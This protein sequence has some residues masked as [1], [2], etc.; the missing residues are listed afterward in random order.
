MPPSQD[1]QPQEPPPP[2]RDAPSA[3]TP[4]D[5]GAD[6][7]IEVSD[8]G[9]GA[10]PS[11]TVDDQ[12]GA[13]AADARLPVLPA[14]D[15]PLRGRSPF[16]ARPNTRRRRALAGASVALAVVLTLA[17]LIVI[18]VPHPGAAL[19]TLLRL[20]TPTATPLLQFGDDQVVV[21]RGVYWGQLTVDGRAVATSA[22]ASQPLQLARGAHRIL[23]RAQFFPT[24]HCRLSVP[25]AG[26][27]TCP[28]LAQSAIDT[29]SGTF[30]RTR[31]LDLQATVNRL[32]AA[33]SQR[34]LTAFMSA[35]AGLTRTGVIAP[36]EQY[37]S[38]HGQVTTATAPLSAT[39][40]P[41]VAASRHLYHA[42][43][44]NSAQ[45]EDACDPLCDFQGSFGVDLQSWPLATYL[46]TAW[47]YGLPT[48]QTITAPR[49]TLPLGQR[50]LP[51]FAWWDAAGWHVSLSPL[52]VGDVEC[53]LGQQQLAQMAVQTSVSGFALEPVPSADV[54]QGCLLL[55]QPPSATQ[56]LSAAAQLLY[57]YG[58]LLAANAMA[59]QLFPSVPP[60][61]A[62]EMVVAQ[63]LAA[64]VQPSPSG[65]T[66]T[67][68]ANA[69]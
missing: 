64:E 19:G 49:P 32:P 33:Q 41:S 6:F 18:S 1:A 38:A 9:A 12:R 56:P 10:T 3:A 31:I 34:L 44:P 37:V 57:R 45:E 52:I 55:Y 65:I 22:L 40:I 21:A 42:G 28:L 5:D 48:G 46:Y 4:P 63:R 53:A 20:P 11:A 17:I 2:L 54:T 8:L 50:I 47:R 62:A 68:V 25:A 16:A 39:L 23:Y 27:D 24:L 30:G 7:E 60:A 67:P 59:R 69:S 66:F 35:L 29:P 13:S 26:D 58:V 36:G 43:Q 15:A 51:F 61:D 14:R